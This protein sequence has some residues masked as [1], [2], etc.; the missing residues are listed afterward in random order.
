M[1]KSEGGVRVTNEPFQSVLLTTETIQQRVRELG[2][3]IT[4][5]YAGRAP[6]I[7]CV[8]KGA[9]IFFSDLVRCVDLPLTVGMISI[10]SYGDATKSS[11]VAKIDQD[12]DISV[13]GRDVLLVEDIVDTGLT[14]SYL[15]DVFERRN[16]HSVKIVALLDKVE[17]RKVEIEP[18]YRGFFVPNQ[19]LVGYGMDY[20][21]RFRH[22]PYVAVLHPDYEGK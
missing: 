13:E 9:I 15:I 21:N 8:L 17:R 18:D 16:A 14:L 5:D 19:F 6:I 2:S 1:P 12:L 11:G 20:A 10:S 3:Q 22:L 7:V 4:K